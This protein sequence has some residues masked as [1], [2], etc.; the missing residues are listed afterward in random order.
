MHFETEGPHLV[1]LVHLRPAPFFF[2][3]NE[4]VVY[5]GRIDRAWDRLTRLAG[6]KFR[7]GSILG[8]VFPGNCLFCSFAL[9]RIEAG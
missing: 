2:L 9:S 4:Y 1:H 6:I 5:Y 8:S 3:M 7:L